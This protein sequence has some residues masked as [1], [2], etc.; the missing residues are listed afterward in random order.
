MKLVARGK[1]VITQ[2]TDPALRP[3]S[4]VKI[5]YFPYLY[6]E[7]PCLLWPVPSLSLS[8]LPFEPD[9]SPRVELCLSGAFC[10]WLCNLRLDQ[11]PT[12][13]G[14]QRL[15][16]DLSQLDWL[17]RLMLFVSFFPSSFACFTFWDLRFGGLLPWEEWKQ[18]Q[19]LGRGILPKE[20]S[21]ERGKS[22][23]AFHRHSALLPRVEE[24][25]TDL[26]GLLWLR[27]SSHFERRRSSPAD[28]NR[29]NSW[30]SC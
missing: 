7:A 10:L 29:F 28:D 5:Y 26:A 17:L 20:I 21:I 30:G 15:L 3:W 9:P 1:K 2:L 4:V 18:N 22:Q 13:I 16:V 24:K 19:T 6:L 12:E 27:Y 11:F 8:A 23:K 14:K 25:A